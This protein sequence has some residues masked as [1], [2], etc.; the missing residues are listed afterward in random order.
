MLCCWWGCRESLKL[1]A[2]R[3]SKLHK[4]GEISW[5]NSDSDMSAWNQLA[6]L[7]FS[8]HSA[9][10]KA[11]SCT[12]SIYGAHS[13]DS[14][15]RIFPHSFSSQW[16]QS[17]CRSLPHNLQACRWL[18]GCQG[19]VGQFPLP[20]DHRWHLLAMELRCRG[21]MSPLVAWMAVEVAVGEKL[22]WEEQ[23]RT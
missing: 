12:S 14:G 9:L 22:R 5:T 1:I 23:M 18:V 21:Q 6:H 11:V 15:M 16:P 8:S 10:Y 20:R 3:L 4:N 17:H 19:V 13:M 7:V 2:V